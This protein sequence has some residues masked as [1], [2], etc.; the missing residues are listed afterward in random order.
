MLSRSDKKDYG[1]FMEPIDEAT[2]NNLDKQNKIKKSILYKSSKGVINEQ[3]IY[4]YGEIDLNNKGDI[5]YLKKFKNAIL[6]PYDISSFIYSKFDY[7]TGN[8]EA[9]ENGIYKGYQIM[10]DVLKWFKF[11]HCIIGKPS[12][13][14][15][16][17]YPIRKYGLS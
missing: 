14:I 1:V 11:N 6:N 4:L 15:I 7:E 3:D 13:I 17:K 16:Y 12:R 2:E 9:D 10:N 5:N 8:V